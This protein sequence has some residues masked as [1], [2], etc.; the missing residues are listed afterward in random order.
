M[1]TARVL[2]KQCHGIFFTAR[3]AEGHKMKSYIMKNTII[4]ASIGIFSANAYSNGVVK[5]PLSFTNESLTRGVNF[6]QGFNYA[7]VG[8][9][10]SMMDLDGDG[11]LDI[12]VAGGLNGEFGLYENDGSGF[13]TDRTA[14]SGFTLMPNV[15]GISAADYDNDG[16][17]DIH[18]PGWKVPSRLYRNDGGLTFT[19]V[20]AFAGID[21]DAPSLGAA[22]GDY[23]QDGFL[24]LYA[25]VRTFT[26]DI[27]IENKLYH[28]NGDGTFTDVAVQ[29]G[30]EAPGDPSCLPAFFD[31]DRD[32]DDDI[33]IGTDKGS[34]TGRMLHNKLYRNEGDGTFTNMTYAANAEAWL[35]C[36]GIAVGDIDFD[37]YFDMY[38]TNVPLGNKL[39]MYD[40]T[41]AAYVDETTAAGMASNITGW[42][43][44]FADFD[45][46]THLDTYVCNMQGLNRLYRGSSV[47]PLVDEASGAGVAVVNDVFCVSV[48]DVDGDNDL[49]MLVSTTNARVNL[50]INN[51]PDAKTN[52]WV[53]FDVVGEETNRF[54]VGTCVEVKTGDKTQ[55]REVRSGVNYKAQ[56]E[57]TLH[58]GLADAPMIDRVEVFFADGTYRKLHGAPMNQN[59]KLYPVSQLGDIN[60]NGHI[61]WEELEQAISERTG[62]GNPI[63]P[64]QEQFDMDGDFDIDN[65]D[66]ILMGLGILE[67]TSH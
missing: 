37:G 48:G 32:G 24:D 59:W 17:L 6:R 65:D 47:W 3:R 4:L 41:S 63:S 52:K 12:L 57:Y 46:D 14:G 31:Y 55:V 10:V 39:L 50:F 11:D 28:N 23:D 67:P 21:V 56:D 9:G 8:A 18:V 27:E 42:S 13:F 61:D 15:S 40:G 22:W 36:M 34:Q 30:V 33:Y 51:S 16:D 66:L 29:L 38:L 5:N 1:F 43:T 25:C 58:F 45:N 35:F 20:G 44:V 7:Q 62:K 19:E 53:R 2:M 60:G 49:D 26:D 54:S 64:G